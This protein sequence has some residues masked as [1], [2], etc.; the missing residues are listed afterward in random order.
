[1]E[2]E[3]GL[4]KEQDN[5]RYDRIM[6]P[7]EREKGGGL[8]EDFGLTNNAYSPSKI[9][10]LGNKEV[11]PE[12]PISIL[13]LNDK[14]P[15]NETKTTLEFVIVSLCQALG[16]SPSQAA[17]LLTDHNYYLMHACVK[18]VKGDYAGILKW[19]Q[20]LFD[21]SQHLIE[22]AVES[23]PMPEEEHGGTLNDSMIKEEDT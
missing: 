3:G 7:D 17:G 16:I 20:L 6:G 22:L 13:Q 11:K 12:Q 10:M 23:L 5:K 18:G 14:R 1:M 21:S 15:L 9:S 8:D 19:Y 4:A 2:L